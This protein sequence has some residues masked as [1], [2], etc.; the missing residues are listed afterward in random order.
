MHVCV[1][2]FMLTADESEGLSVGKGVYLKATT[3]FPV[4]C[5][6]IDISGMPIFTLYCAHL[7]LY[8]YT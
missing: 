5:V 2:V 4:G 8:L 3:S 1:C 6:K 7:S